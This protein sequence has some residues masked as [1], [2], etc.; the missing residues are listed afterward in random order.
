MTMMLTLMLMEVQ[1]SQIEDMISRDR[2]CGRGHG[3]SRKGGLGFLPV[4]PVWVPLAAAV[5]VIAAA[6]RVQ[7]GSCAFIQKAMPKCKR[8]AN[9]LKSAPQ[10]ERGFD[11][12]NKDIVHNSPTDSSPPNHD[13]ITQDGTIKTRR[14][15]VKEMDNLTRD[16]QVIVNFEDQQ[17]I[18][19]SQGL[20]AGYLRTL[21]VDCK[22]FP[23]NFSKWSGPL[24][25]PRSR[26][27]ECFSNLLKPKFHFKISE[28]IAKRYCKLNLAK[29]WSQ[30][31]IKL[32][33]EFY[34]PCMSRQAIIDNVPV[35][36]DRDQWA[37]F[38]QYRFLP[39]TMEMCRRNKEVRKKQTISHTGGSKP[40]S[41]KRH[42]IFLQTGRKISRGEMYIATHKKKDGSFVTDEARNIAE[43]IELLMTQNE[44]DESGPSTNDAIGKV[45]GEEHS[46]R[47]RCLGMGATPT[48]TFRGANHPGQFANSSI[49]MS[50]TNYSQTDFKRLESKFDGTLTALK[51]YFL[52][53]EGRIPANDVE[54]EIITPATERASSS[55]GSNENCEDIV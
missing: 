7:S 26:F 34:D 15:K 18:G 10:S 22:L 24:G 12:S 46:G 40:I 25:I 52:S 32:W 53:K 38:I 45:F 48:N 19:E 35:G 27:E 13:S 42:E 1:N 43:Q 21:A 33:N 20:L 17:A 54:N 39:F 51:A 2:D 4:A 44:K 37:S 49:S 11:Q 5:H 9:P 30:H 14:L 16:E 8:F 41:R 55:G 23:I 31:R 28:G 3:R 36:I 47:V 29:K 50:S 6:V